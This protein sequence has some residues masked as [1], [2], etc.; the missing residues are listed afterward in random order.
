MKKIFLS[1][2]LIVLTISCSSPSNDS[3]SSINSGNWE[4]IN[5]SGEI[6]SICTVGNNMFIGNSVGVYRSTDNGNNWSL[7][8]NVASG[9]V[10]NV[11]TFNGE[12]YCSESLLS[13][14]NALNYYKSSNGDS[15][16][17]VYTTMQINGLSKPRRI[18]LLGSKLF[19]VSGSYPANI[20]SSNDN[21]NTW[22][23]L[24]SNNNYTNLIP[25]D[26]SFLYDGNAYFFIEDNYIYKSTDG[27]NFNKISNSQ[28]NSGLDRYGTVLGN[29]IFI[30]GYGV[31][32]TSDSGN[33]WSSTNNGIAYSTGAPPQ[34]YSLDNN[35]QNIFA[36]AANGVYLLDNSNSIWT[37]IENSPTAANGVSKCLVSNSSYIFSVYSNSN[38][39]ASCTIYRHTL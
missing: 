25:P 13:S 30:G 2:I 27:T 5:F 4:Q 3:N 28:I 1:L 20:I 15:W 39:P 18:Y 36:G 33:T 6:N 19:G 10:L 8:K 17:P 32:T 9:N 37:K 34:L 38:T 31:I 14:Q 12:I 35:G 22:I 26:V 21:G 11:F 24:S 29:R 23:I 16:S 7:V